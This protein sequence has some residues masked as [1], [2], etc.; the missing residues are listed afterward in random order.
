MIQA[1]VFIE[2]EPGRVQELVDELAG[3]KLAAS[4]IKQVHAVTGRWDLIA[5]IESPDLPSL[6]D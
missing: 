4:V 6:G 1:F 2:A 5:L 3:M